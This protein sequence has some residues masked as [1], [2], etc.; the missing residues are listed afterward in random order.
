[1]T[2][3]PIP[4][5]NDILYVSSTTDGIVG[6]A[7]FADED[8]L[9]LNR[10]TGAWSLYFDGSDVGITSDVDAFALMTDGTILVSLDTDGTVT[11]FGTVDDSDI[12]RFTS[13]SLGSNTTGSFTWYFDGSDV[14]LTTT[15]EDVDAIS[16]SPDGKLILSTVG[17]FSVTGASGND[18]DLI[19]FTASTLGTTTTGTW[20]LYF[21]GSDVGLNT[22]TSEQINGIWI[23]RTNG[24]IYLT[25]IGAFSVTGLSGTGSDIFICTP[26][27]LGAITTCS[28]SSY[29]TGASNGFGGEIVDGIHISR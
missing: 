23:D 4:G 18:E 21:D 19:A 14:G 10:S 26:G 28:Y 11:G 16:F 29:W 3:T 7:S 2:N 27:T 13:T 15:A 12:L 5:A 1:V 17:A 9:S 24:K 6:G 8:I 20:S 22:T 25:T